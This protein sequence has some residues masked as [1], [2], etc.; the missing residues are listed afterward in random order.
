M[1]FIT[2]I[3]LGFGLAM[4][5]VAVSMTAGFIVEKIRF[6]HILKMSLCFGFFQSAMAIIGFCAGMG[7]IRLI[8]KFDHWIAFGLLC[9]VGIRM[10]Y[11]A[12][13]KEHDEKKVDPLNNYTLFILSVATSIDSLAV[14]LSLSFLQVSIIM[15]VAVIGIISFLLSLLAAYA[16]KFFG[17]IL[18]GKMEIIGGIILIGIGIKILIEHISN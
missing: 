8:E 12:L 14:G 11:E 9:F 16:G 2:S 18:G 10:I 17:K 4:D 6:R 15:P 1:D 7:I 3:L 13:K 5:C